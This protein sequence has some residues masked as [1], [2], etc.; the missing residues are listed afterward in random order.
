[1][2]H[3]NK[4]L[5]KE[6]L[7]T[8]EFGFFGA[9]RYLGAFEEQVRI[10]AFAEEPKES[11]RWNWVKR[12]AEWVL[13]RFDQSRRERGLPA[14]NPI[15]LIRKPGGTRRHRDEHGRKSEAEPAAL[16]GGGHGRRHFSAEA[17]STKTHRIPNVA[18]HSAPTMGASAT[19]HPTNAIPAIESHS[20]TLSRN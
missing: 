15:Q 9:S 11:G 17:R 5:G 6:A 12:S 7:Y 4:R 19:S 20:C 1:R 10:A 16:G 3:I 18:P 8:I 2:L 14:A 13:A